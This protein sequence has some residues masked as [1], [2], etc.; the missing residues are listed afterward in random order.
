MIAFSRKWVTE[1]PI[2]YFQYIHTIRMTQILNHEALRSIFLSV[3]SPIYAHC[4]MTADMAMHTLLFC[5]SWAAERMSLFERLGLQVLDRTY[6]TVRAAICSAMYW[7]TLAGG[8]CEAVIR[9]KKRVEWKRQ[10]LK[11]QRILLARV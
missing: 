6:S 9:K 7:T 11:K 4:H 10:A 8:F 1:D 3:T 5:P 2:L